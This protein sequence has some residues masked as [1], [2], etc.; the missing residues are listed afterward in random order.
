MTASRPSDERQQLREALERLANAGSKTLSLNN[1]E[2]WEE[3]HDAIGQARAAL[4]APS[5]P[6]FAVEMMPDGHKAV[7]V[8][9]PA[10]LD[11]ERLARALAYVQ[12]S[13][14]FVNASEWMDSGLA[15]AIAA[16]YEEQK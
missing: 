2:E 15:A 6:T 3:L 11:V 4:A 9:P 14:G 13:A 10:P 1:D 12:P 5:A 16:A 7:I 8:D